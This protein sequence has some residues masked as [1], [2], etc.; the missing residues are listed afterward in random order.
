MIC[1]I[2]WERKGGD[3]CCRQIISQFGFQP[4]KVLYCIPDNWASSISSPSFLKT[5]TGISL[6]IRNIFFVGEWR[7]QMT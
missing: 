5:D 2:F 1:I 7:P 6:P 4:E 3:R